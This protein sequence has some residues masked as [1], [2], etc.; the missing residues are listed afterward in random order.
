MRVLQ[1][2]EIP[3]GVHLDHVVSLVLW[4]W[5][6]AFE[7]TFLGDVYRLWPGALRSLKERFSSAMGRF[8]TAHPQAAIVAMAPGTWWFR[9]TP[10]AG[11][12]RLPA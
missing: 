12:G 11:L 7:V 10:G 5:S 3:E 6:R 4:A 2:D 8:R 9:G 1:P